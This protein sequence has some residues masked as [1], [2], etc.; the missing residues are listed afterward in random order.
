MRVNLQRP[1]IFHRL[2]QRSGEVENCDPSCVVSA[3][4]LF[5]GTTRAPA[6]LNRTHRTAEPRGERQTPV[7]TLGPGQRAA[8][9]TACP[10]AFLRTPACRHRSFAVAQP[11]APGDAVADTSWYLLDTGRPCAEG[12]HS[13]NRQPRP[14]RRALGDVLRI[15]VTG[16]RGHLLPCGPPARPRLCPLSP[17]SGASDS[18]NVLKSMWNLLCKAKTRHKPNLSSYEPPPPRRHRACI[19]PE[20]M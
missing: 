8:G 7:S 10:L 18:A 2:Q 11:A 14:G 3:R 19:T 4:G 9:S 5:G 17:T 12:G 13:G 15:G 1:K 20:L 6:L 16:S